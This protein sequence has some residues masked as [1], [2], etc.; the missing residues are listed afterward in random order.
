[1]P[2]GLG[3]VMKVLVLAKGVDAPVLRGCS[4]RT[5]LT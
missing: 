3:S 1:M 2:G 5:R 4:G